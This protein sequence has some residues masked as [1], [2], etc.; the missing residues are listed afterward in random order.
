M[1]LYNDPLVKAWGH[2]WRQ[3][4]QQPLLDYHVTL[5]PSAL[6]LRSSGIRNSPELTEIDTKSLD[7]HLK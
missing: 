5:S 1:S 2:V 3:V 6:E 4:F 7:L